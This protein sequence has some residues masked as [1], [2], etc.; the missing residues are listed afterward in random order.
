MESRRPAL[1]MKSVNSED[2][3]KKTEFRDGSL[4]PNIF[5]DKMF[6]K[7]QK[8]QT[9]R[10]KKDQPPLLTP[11]PLMD[12]LGLFCNHPLLGQ[13]AFSSGP[14]AA[15]LEFCPRHPPPP[16]PQLEPLSL[17]AD[18]LTA[19]TTPSELARALAGAMRTSIRR[20]R[21]V[22]Q[23]GGYPFRAGLKGRPNRE[24]PV[25]RKTHPCTSPPLRHGTWGLLVKGWSPKPR[26]RASN[27]NPSQSKPPRKGYPL[28]ARFT[29]M[30]PD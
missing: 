10:T 5:T 27:P 23:W 14:S 30:E 29:N 18:R 1:E 17:A 7:H 24:P 21:L 25:K 11:P 12:T 3:S 8:G 16:R 20:R 2:N 26:T 19:T 4:P 28:P 15:K 22:L 9:K 13:F 6:A